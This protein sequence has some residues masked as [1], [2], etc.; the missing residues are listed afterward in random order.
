MGFDCLI[1]EILLAAGC[2]RE[3][4]DIAVVLVLFGRTTF[5]CGMIG[6]DDIAIA[7]VV[8]LFGLLFDVTGI[9]WACVFVI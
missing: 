7:C 1:E 6:G 2:R 5:S 8:F 4:G 9:I 3:A